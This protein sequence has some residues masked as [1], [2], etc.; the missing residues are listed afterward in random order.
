MLRQNSSRIV[1]FTVW[2][3]LLLWLSF[4]SLVLLE[5]VA[6]EVE[7]A[8]ATNGYD[9]EFEALATLALAVQPGSLSLESTSPS[10]VIALLSGPALAGIPHSVCHSSDR[11]AALI[12]PE[13]SRHKRLCTYRI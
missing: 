5:Q 9:P 3:L 7:D 8:Q 12:P 4:G 10:L 1:G 6:P 13:R 2:T 11:F